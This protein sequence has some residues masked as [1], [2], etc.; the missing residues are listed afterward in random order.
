MNKMGNSQ[1]PYR[2]AL[3]HL[4]GMGSKKINYKKAVTILTKAFKTKVPYTTALLGWCYAVGYGVEMDEKKAGEIWQSDP[5]CPFC[6]KE[7]AWCYKWG[8]YDLPQ[9]I[10]KSEELLKTAIPK[11]MHLA[12][13][14]D[15][16]AQY[17]LAYCYRW[18]LGF[19]KED[20]DNA[21]K[22]YFRSALNSHAESECQYGLLSITKDKTKEIAVQWFKKSADQ[23]CREAQFELGWCYLR[24]EGVKQNTETAKFW[25]QL[26]AK[27]GYT[28]AEIKL[29]Q[30]LSQA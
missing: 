13:L 20:Y 3:C 17:Q 16:H 30:M 11:I 10:K 14:E 15:P 5:E 2:D 18:A 27:N 29:K 4:Y 22:W 12:E 1:S 8:Q 25:Y 28:P 26:S 9:D 6:Q 19:P 23:N 24:A 7:L 21:T